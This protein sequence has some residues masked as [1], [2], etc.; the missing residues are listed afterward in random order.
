M[1]RE[2]A[3][4]IINLKKDQEKRQHITD[5]CRQHQIDFEIIP[6]VN[7][8]ALDEKYVQTVY[9]ENASVRNIGRSMS[10]GE[11]GCALSHRHIY[12][13]MISEGIDV[14]LVL[15]DDIDFDEDLP[16]LLH[17]ID[18]FPDDWDVVLL[19]HHSAW[20]RDQDTAYSIWGKRRL[21]CRYSVVRPVEMGCGTYGYLIRVTGAKKLVADTRVL[22][23]PID[24]YTGSDEN[25]N[26]Y[27]VH[28]PVIR[29]HQHL[30]DHHHSMH[31]RDVLHEQRAERQLSWKGKLLARLH[32][33]AVWRELKIGLLNLRRVLKRQRHYV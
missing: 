8:K 22:Y 4:F 19:G 27:M 28:P 33:K 30:S 14:A 6:A 12:E 7:G 10:R 16:D 18:E 5:L 26:L 9:Y 17:R 29:I 31:D 20:S 24:H 32:M 21:N 13:T 11:I 15:E 3:V 23:Q 25:V 1:N 2:L